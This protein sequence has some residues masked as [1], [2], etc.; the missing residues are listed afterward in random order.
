MIFMSIGPINVTLLGAVLS[1]EKASES[2]VP[3]A[4]VVNNGYT[5]NTYCHS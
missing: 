1:F 3:V 4:L 5:E 2:V